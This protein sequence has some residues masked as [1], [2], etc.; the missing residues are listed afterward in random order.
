MTEMGTPLLETTITTTARPRAGQAS[1]ADTS[2]VP[3]D[4]PVE[5]VSPLR[6]CHLS[7]AHWPEMQ[8]TTTIQHVHSRSVNI[9]ENKDGSLRLLPVA[10][11]SKKSRIKKVEKMVT[12][13]PRIR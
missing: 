5:R 7:E 13:A 8:T 12:F 6:Y 9:E 10:S 1:R 11:S 3:L 2:L 4:N